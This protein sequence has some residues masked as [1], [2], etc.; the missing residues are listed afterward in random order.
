MNRAFTQEDP[1]GI[2]GGLNLYGYANGD[3]INFS[4]PLGLRAEGD[5]CDG[6]V[7]C[8]RQFLKN[9]WEG[10]TTPLD[11]GPPEGGSAGWLAGR[12]LLALPTAR[13]PTGVGAGAVAAEG[14][15]TAEMSGMLRAAAA[16][17][18][19]FGIG[20]T[21]AGTADDLGR[22]WVGEGV[23]VASDG[24]TLLSANGLRQYRPPSFKPSRGLTQANLE[25]RLRPGG[26]WQGNAHIDIIVPR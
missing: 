25:W 2:A 23:S 10:F 17:K 4:D 21:T 3:P 6:F 26:A 16:G 18:G 12:L 13:T 22:A 5:E 19:N 8:A 7:A 9:Q 11:Q 15:A 14:A 24:R 1:I 20:S